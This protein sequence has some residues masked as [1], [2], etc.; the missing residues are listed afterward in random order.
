[1]IAVEHQP[2][3]H[4]KVTY[5]LVTIW[6]TEAEA[7]EAATNQAAAAALMRRLHDMRA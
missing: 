7:Q 6:I 1:M 3:G 5:N 2:N 4:V